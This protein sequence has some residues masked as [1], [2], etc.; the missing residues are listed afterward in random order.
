MPNPEG[1]QPSPAETRAAE[2]TMDDTQRELTETRE[3]SLFEGRKQA[4]E[5]NPAEENEAAKEME[6]LDGLILSLFEQDTLLGGD[7]VTGRLDGMGY[8]YEDGKV[9]A[10]L[11]RLAN[12]GKIDEPSYGRGMK[13][14]LKG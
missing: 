11:Y 7:Q 9:Y 5:Q 3:D 2:A 8:K 4:S 14:K 10:S 12:S 6:K 13:W 1:Y